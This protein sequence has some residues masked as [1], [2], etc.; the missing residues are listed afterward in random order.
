MTSRTE[1]EKRLESAELYTLRRGS[2]FRLAEQDRISRPP[3]DDIPITKD[4]VFIMQGLD[5]MY[6]KVDTERG[7][8]I[9]LAAWTKVI[10]YE[11]N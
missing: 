10:P 3:A 7:E 6:C 11:N 1:Q 2:K 4:E 8:R 5:G 9:Y